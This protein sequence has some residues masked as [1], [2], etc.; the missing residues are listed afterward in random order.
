MGS[1]SL[2][3]G[4]KGGGG[5]DIFASQLRL[6]RT[7]MS[8]IMTRT[9]QTHCGTVVYCEPIAGLWYIDLKK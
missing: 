7:H 6:Y 2:H 5:H 4:S 1:E 3:S 9:V 8:V